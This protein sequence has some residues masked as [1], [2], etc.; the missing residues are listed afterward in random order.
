MRKAAAAKAAA[1]VA[2]KGQADVYGKPA[3]ALV[4]SYQ[5]PASTPEITQPP[6]QPNEDARVPLLARQIPQTKEQAIQ[7]VLAKDAGIVVPVKGPPPVIPANPQIPGGGN[8]IGPTLADDERELANAVY[9]ATSKPVPEIVAKWASLRGRQATTSELRNVIGNVLKDV[10]LVGIEDP[11]YRMKLEKIMRRWLDLLDERAKS[12]KPVQ[13]VNAT[14]G[15]GIPQPNRFKSPPLPPITKEGLE[16]AEKASREGAAADIAKQDA[17]TKEVTVEALRVALAKVAAVT[18]S[19]SIAASMA[20]ETVKKRAQ[21]LAAAK[22]NAAAVLT[23][24]TSSEDE[25]SK[26][27]SLLRDAGEAKALAEKQ[28]REATAKEQASLAEKVRLEQ[29]IEEMEKAALRAK[30]DA[31]GKEERAADAEKRVVGAEEK[32]LM[33]AAVMPP[34]DVPGTTKPESI[35]GLGAAPDAGIGLGTIFLGLVAVGA[36]VYALDAQKKNNSGP[37]TLIETLE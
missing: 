33:R 14:T 34:R 9:Q 12:R 27:E 30:D 2:P 32:G 5:P 19:F 11:D 6:R 15:S 4:Q 22:A 23:S 13:D 31:R 10:P 20:R 8:I 24:Q 3:T 29:A 17:I 18:K 25:K 35:Q 21:E 36:V 37:P 1:K 16:A 26:A 7:K 28:A